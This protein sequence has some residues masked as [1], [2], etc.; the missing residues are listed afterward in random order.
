M[1]DPYVYVVSGDPIVS[2]GTGRQGVSHA[3]A[4]SVLLRV[5]LMLLP[6]SC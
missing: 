6:M 3:K 5:L 4:K 1:S 2:I